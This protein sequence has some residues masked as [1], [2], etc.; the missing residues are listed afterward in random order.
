MDNAAISKDAI[1]VTPSDST[2]VNAN[3]VLY[4]GG[5]CIVETAA[6]L[7]GSATTVTLPAAFA[8]IPIPLQIKRVLAASTATA[9][10]AFK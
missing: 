7:Q 6:N 5:T 9:I 2:P 4:T 8:G 10:L 3:G 1:I